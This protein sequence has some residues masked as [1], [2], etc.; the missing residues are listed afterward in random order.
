MNKK[1][2]G[3]GGIASMTVRITMLQAEYLVVR[4]TVMLH[5]DKI[6]IVKR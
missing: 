3:G 2:G 4:N 6:I 5:C 1:G